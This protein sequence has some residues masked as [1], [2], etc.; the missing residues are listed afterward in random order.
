MS[1]SGVMMDVDA[2]G[3]WM[4]A[5]GLA[6]GAPIETDFV[7]GGTQNEIFE[8]RRVHNDITFIDTFL[9]PEFCVRHN[10]F[11][12]AWQEQYRFKEFVTLPK[13]TRLDVKITF[14]NSADNPHNPTSPPKRV[15][16]GRESTDE[17]GMGIFPRINCR[18]SEPSSARSSGMRQPSSAAASK[19]S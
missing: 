16:W 7:A 11:T 2:L 13:G 19:T 8:V 1:E 17:M 9:T 10:L 15:R 3:A 14:D 12:F 6:P 18:L 4:D 5:Q